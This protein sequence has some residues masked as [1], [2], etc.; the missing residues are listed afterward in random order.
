VDGNEQVWLVMTTLEQLEMFE[1]QQR[2]LERQARGVCRLLERTSGAVRHRHW[3]RLLEISARNEQL[4][5]E[6]EKFQAREL[7]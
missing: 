3:R 5:R 4:L 7:S 1:A 2:W 6:F